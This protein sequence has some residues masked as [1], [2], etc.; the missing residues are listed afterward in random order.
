MADID[1]DI[2]PNVYIFCD[3]ELRTN[4]TDLVSSVETCII[5]KS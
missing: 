1:K 5:L 2:D 4:T 3:Q